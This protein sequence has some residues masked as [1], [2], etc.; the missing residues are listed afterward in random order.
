MSFSMT[1]KTQNTMLGCPFAYWNGYSSEQ[2]STHPL[3]EFAAGPLLC[4]K[5]TQSLLSKIFNVVLL[6]VVLEVYMT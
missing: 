4:D 2:K 3:T 6:S 1:I 5:N